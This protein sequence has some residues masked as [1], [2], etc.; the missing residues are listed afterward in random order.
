M[1]LISA[2]S[3]PLSLAVCKVVFPVFITIKIY[4]AEMES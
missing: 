1:F 2:T 4:T 3:T